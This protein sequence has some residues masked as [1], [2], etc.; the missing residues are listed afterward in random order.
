[1]DIIEE[2][3]GEEFD[4]GDEIDVED[5]DSEDSGCE[6][7]D[8]SSDQK[9]YPCPFCHVKFGKKRDYKPKKTLKKVET[10]GGGYVI[11]GA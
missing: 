7:S 1:M 6:T 8:S 11:N 4:E 10:V 2:F 3:E 5:K 9:G